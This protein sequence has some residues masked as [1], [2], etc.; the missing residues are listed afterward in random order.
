MKEIR[1][2]KKKKKE[3]KSEP[4]GPTRTSRPVICAARS[5]RFYPPLAP[6]QPAR[7]SPRVPSIFF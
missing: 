3:K 6:G 7:A 1:K 5:G 4:T 2:Q